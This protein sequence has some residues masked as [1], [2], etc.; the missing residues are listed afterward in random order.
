M[1]VKSPYH[2]QEPFGEGRRKHPP[3]G[4]TASEPG[5][6]GNGHDAGDGKWETEL[7]PEFQHGGYGGLLCHEERGNRSSGGAGFFKAVYGDSGT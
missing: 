6:G 5:S 4:R 2:A 1:A 7:Y 3:F